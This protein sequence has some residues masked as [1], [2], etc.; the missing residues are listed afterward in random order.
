MGS[1]VCS[2]AVPLLTLA[3]EEAEFD[4]WAPSLMD[5]PVEEGT[6]GFPFVAV[7][8]APALFWFST[9]LVEELAE[10][11]VETSEVEELPVLVVCVLSV[12]DAALASGVVLTCVL[13]DAAAAAK[14]CGAPAPSAAGC[15]EHP[16]INTVRLIKEYNAEFR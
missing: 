14:D 15:G 9:T 10:P 3:G 6:T 12:P 7:A 2:V 4:D 1:C 8:P 16:A 11:T 13:D 5:S